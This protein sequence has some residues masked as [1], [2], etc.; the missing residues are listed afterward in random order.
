METGTQ[1]QA[2]SQPDPATVL[3]AEILSWA[4]PLLMS[5]QGGH[6]DVGCRRF[7][8]PATGTAFEYVTVVEQTIE[9]S[10]DSGH[11]AQ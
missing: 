9:H 4:I 5:G 8:T 3:L 2:P 1:D 6:G 7:G 10:G 11:V